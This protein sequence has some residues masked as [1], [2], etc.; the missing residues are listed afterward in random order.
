MAIQVFNLTDKVLDLIDN[1][2]ANFSSVE[3]SLNSIGSSADW[4]T[5]AAS[6]GGT[7][8]YCK[9][10]GIVFISLQDVACSTSSWLSLVTL[11][12]GFR[13]EF[14]TRCALAYNGNGAANGEA[15]IASDGVLKTFG[16]DSQPYWHGSLSYPA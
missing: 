4:V 2:N 11:P 5:V 3:G 10:N 12:V 1:L 7:V 16:T 9:K 15:T 14:D 13:P 8:K 6:G